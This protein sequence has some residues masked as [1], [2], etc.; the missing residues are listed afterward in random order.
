MNYELNSERMTLDIIISFQFC[1]ISGRLLSSV[2]LEPASLAQ[3]YVIV[4]KV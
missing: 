2:V 4:T 1:G 3:V